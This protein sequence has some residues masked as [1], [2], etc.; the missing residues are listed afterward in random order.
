MQ[1]IE[2]P[3]CGAMTY[4]EKDQQSSTGWKCSKCQIPCVVKK[5]KNK[6]SIE[7]EENKNE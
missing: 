3:K 1:E 2:C 7:I 6:Q 4:L 5:S